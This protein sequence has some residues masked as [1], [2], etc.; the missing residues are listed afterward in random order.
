MAVIYFN[1]SNVW[2]KATNNTQVESW[3]DTKPDAVTK[4]TIDENLYTDF[5]TGRQIPTFDGVNITWSIVDKELCSWYTLPQLN[6]GRTEIT[7]VIDLI[8]RNH[9][10][11]QIPF[12]N[13][14]LQY[15]E[16][17]KNYDLSQFKTTTVDINGQPTQRWIGHNFDDVLKRNDKTILFPYHCFA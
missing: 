14:L 2:W 11:E 5:I 7:S 15:R 6:Q 12:L 16:T 10:P 8:E 1:N 13:D 9:R 4:K 17:L 3:L